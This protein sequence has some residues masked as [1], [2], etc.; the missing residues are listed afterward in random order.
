MLHLRLG[1]FVNLPYYLYHSLKRACTQFR[2]GHEHSLAHHGL[3]KLLVIHGLQLQETPI[4]WDAFAYPTFH[5]SQP[6]QKATATLIEEQSSPRHDP[7]ITPAD[8]PLQTPKKGLRISS[9]TNTPSPSSVRRN[10][11]RTANRLENLADAAHAARNAEVEILTSS[12][13]KKR[14]EK[15]DRE[16]RHQARHV[17]RQRKAP[18]IESLLNSA[19]E[20]DNV[21]E[22]DTPTDPCAPSAELQSPKVNA[23]GGTL[24][25]QISKSNEKEMSPDKAVESQKINPDQEDGGQQTLEVGKKF[26]SDALWEDNILQPTPQKT[27]EQDEAHFKQN[28]TDVI[29]PLQKETP[30]GDATGTT[31][32][33]CHSEL[34]TAMIPQSLT[35]SAMSSQDLLSTSGLPLNPIPLQTAIP[36][37]SMITVNEFLHT[38]LQLQQELQQFRSQVILQDD[39]HRPV[40]KESVEH[41]DNNIPPGLYTLF[42]MRTCKS[43]SWGEMMSPDNALFLLTFCL[44][45]CPLLWHK[46]PF[47][48]TY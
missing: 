33:S 3:I 9:R 48:L 41:P 5:A 31:E 42:C 11:P 12:S 2:D 4:V 10:P 32:S 46:I 24:E 19:N 18:F 13:N 30:L 47:L 44:I 27:H 35:V 45:H 37:I 15:V 21:N 26:E 17:K 38:F 29:E 8:A 39:V 20:E 36:G 6:Q 16:S 22:G 23:E 40:P 28:P 43:F 7:E 14:K 1:Q 25:G 34:D